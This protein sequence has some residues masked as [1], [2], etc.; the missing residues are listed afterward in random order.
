MTEVRMI[1]ETMVIHVRGIVC[2]FGN[3]FDITLFYMSV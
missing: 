1:L 3:I 2:H